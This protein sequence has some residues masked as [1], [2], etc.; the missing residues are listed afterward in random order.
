MVELAHLLLVINC[1]LNFPV[2]FLAS[3]TKIGN[4]CYSFGLGL[5]KELDNAQVYDDCTNG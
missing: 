4:V 5:V 3:D 1:S 2:Y